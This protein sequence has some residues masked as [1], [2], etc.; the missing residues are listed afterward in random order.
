MAADGS[1]RTATTER[2]HQMS[3]TL[4]PE[5]QSSASLRAVT[6]DLYRDVHKGI[7]AELFSLTSQAGQIDPAGRRHRVALAERVRE[8]RE[9]LVTHAEHED[10][11]I[12]P[13]LQTVLPQLSERVELEHAGLEANLD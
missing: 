5:S 2:N 13:V 7:R 1:A 3:V 4:D 11:E 12:T 10:T 9:M 6:F 8:T